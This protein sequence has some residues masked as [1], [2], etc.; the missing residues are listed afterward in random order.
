MREGNNEKE[1]VKQTNKTEKEKK[2]RSQGI[3]KK[4]ENVGKKVT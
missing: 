4:E 1:Q 2:R 3:K